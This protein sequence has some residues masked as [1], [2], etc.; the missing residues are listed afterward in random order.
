[1]NK[2]VL[3]NDRLDYVV[4]VYFSDRIH[5]STGY[6]SSDRFSKVTVHVHYVLYIRQRDICITTLIESFHR[7][8]PFHETHRLFTT[9]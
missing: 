2:L 8:Y 1:M 4:F 3:R 5:Y 9:E 7:K 6:D